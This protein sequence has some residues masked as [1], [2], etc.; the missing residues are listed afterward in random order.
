MKYGLHTLTE[1]VSPNAAGK[2]EVKRGGRKG[3]RQREDG[4]E[5][6]V[7]GRQWCLTRNLRKGKLWAVS[8]RNQ[9]AVQEAISYP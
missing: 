3:S 1:Q 4:I 6:C 2:K 7:E 5:L 9:K 8:L